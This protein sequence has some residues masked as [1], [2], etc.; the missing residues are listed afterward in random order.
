MTLNK[1]NRGN[2]TGTVTV[3]V[4]DADANQITA[5]SQAKVAGESVSVRLLEGE[6]YVLDNENTETSLVIQ[7]DDV[8][9]V[10]IVEVGKHTTVAEEESTTFAVSLLS[11]PTKPVTLTL[12]PGAE[13]EFVDPINAKTAQV[14]KQNFSFDTNAANNNNLD[15][16]LKSLVNTDQ[17]DAIVLEVKLKNKPTKDINIELFDGNDTTPQPFQLSFT[18]EGAIDQVSGQV[19]SG[20]WDQVQEVVIYNLDQDARGK[21]NLQAKID[22]KLIDFPIN[23]TTTQIT[24][25]STSIT[26]NPE[27]W[28]KLQTV[29]IQGRPDAVAEPGIYHTSGVKYQLTSADTNYNNLFVP[30]QKIQVVDRKL[31]PQETASVMA[32]GLD[33]L[34]ESIDNLT[35]PLVGNL[36]DKKPKSS[37]GFRLTISQGN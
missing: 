16:K 31:N 36:D 32:Q 33:L 19:K 2:F 26:I 17:G 25:K 10:R 15:I 18:A 6:G 14:N 27:D 9:G 4:D 20:N 37:R 21:Y 5:N 28:Y 30:D 1:N 7:D 35:L 23:Q 11:E 34:Q 29:T 3:E 24:Q 12:T 8:P 22:G 13:V